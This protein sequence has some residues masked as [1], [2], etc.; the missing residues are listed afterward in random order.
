MK[1]KDYVILWYFSIAD[2]VISLCFFAL[3]FIK[4]WDVAY[5][6]PFAVLSLAFIIMYGLCYKPLKYDNGY[7]LIQA[8][9]YCRAC[10]RKGFKDGFSVAERKILSN[11]SAEMELLADYELTDKLAFYNSGKEIVDSMDNT[12]VLRCWKIQDRY[13]LTKTNKIERTKK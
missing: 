8:V 11:V 13:L 2:L 5:S 3:C 10:R 4:Y 12:L 9:S 7:N 1:K 6:I